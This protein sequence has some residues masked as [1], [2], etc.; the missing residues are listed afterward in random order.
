MGDYSEHCFICLK[1]WTDDDL[2]EEI[3]EGVHKRCDKRLLTIGKLFGKR[4]SGA[5]EWMR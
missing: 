2:W 1:K 3:Q 5:E 4:Q